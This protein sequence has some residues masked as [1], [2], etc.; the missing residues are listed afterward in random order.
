MNPY[1]LG[2][3]IALCLILGAVGRHSRLGAIGIFL[4]ALV[5]TPILVGMVLV[6]L[7]PL[8]RLSHHINTKHQPEIER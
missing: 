1:M 8:P 7:R 3:Y 2:L 4:L 6:V 5:F